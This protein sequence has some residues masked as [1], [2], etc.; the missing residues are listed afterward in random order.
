MKFRLLFLITLSALSL[1]AFAQ[2]KV[3]ALR[4]T[5][6]GDGSLNKA[7]LSV[8]HS[9]IV[10]AASKSSQYLVLDHSSIDAVKAELEYMNSGAVDDND[11][12][13]S[14]GGKLQ[15]A[16]YVIVSKANAYEKDIFLTIQMINIETGEIVDSQNGSCKADPKEIYKACAE[17]AGKILGVS[18][19]VADVTTPHVG[20]KP[21]DDTPAVK[22]RDAETM[23]VDVDG[24]PLVLVHVDGGTFT[25]GCS[26]EQEGACDD[27]EQ[28]A[29]QVTVGSFYI[30]MLEVTQELWE[31]VMGSDVYQQRNADNIGWPLCGEGPDYPMYY[32]S[33]SEA[34]E[35]CQRLSRLTGRQFALPTEAEWEYA[36]RGGKKATDTRYS[37]SVSIDDV[38]WYKGNS[39]ASVHTCC[40]KCANAL[41]IYDMSGN[42]QEWCEDV[43]GPYQSADSDSP[44]GE[45]APIHVLRGGCW[46]N[47]AEACRVSSRD[48][49][50][51]GVPYPYFGFRIVMR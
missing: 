44:K 1:S 14:K 25:M 20:T 29:H 26:G 27:D 28:P 11:R 35:F 36:A 6:C 34:R 5:V 15:A 9:A 22:P 32:V 16:Q 47:E 40:F 2:Q 31:K 23:T 39:E 50:G 42:V 24:I 45:K 37:G 43:Y 21:K 13:K 3:V 46:A 10:A 8:I 19:P 17:L 38:A 49:Y 7:Q 41:G 48:G 4:E 12:A 18:S 33:W 30:G 51:L